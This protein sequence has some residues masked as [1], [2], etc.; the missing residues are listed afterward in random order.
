[1]SSVKMF[2]SP[3]KLEPLVT[4][5]PP[6][7][8]ADTF[9]SGVSPFPNIA[10]SCVDAHDLYNGELELAWAA[11]DENVLEWTAA[12]VADMMAKQ[13][14]ACLED[15]LRTLPARSCSIDAFIVAYPTLDTRGATLPT[16][17]DLVRLVRR[18]HHLFSFDGA[19]GTV[20]LALA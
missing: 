17:G 6:M 12:D 19:S 10:V 7:A 11:G 5:P 9:F 20:A 15:H 4:R 13:W 14:V 2:K 1:M 18:Y 3:L 8:P 16:R